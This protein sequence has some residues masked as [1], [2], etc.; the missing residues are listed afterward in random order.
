MVRK[1][2]IDEIRRIRRSG[3]GQFAV[4]FMKLSELLRKKT[5][6][7]G[8]AC[9]LADIRIELDSNPCNGSQPGGGGARRDSNG[10]L[11]LMRERKEKGVMEGSE[12][13]GEYVAPPAG[14]E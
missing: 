2:K 11:H 7:V 4:A 1:L 6:V 9:C 14:P 5:K 12:E 8:I 3:R 13:S 10:Q